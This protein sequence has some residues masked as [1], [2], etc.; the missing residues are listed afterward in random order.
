M[1][2]C[3]R[4]YVQIARIEL[5]CDTTKFA[6]DSG[7]YVEIWNFTIRFWILIPNSKRIPHA[8]PRIDVPRCRRSASRAR[9][10]FL[11]SHTSRYGSRPFGWWRRSERGRSQLAE[12]DLRARCKAEAHLFHRAVR[13]LQPPRC[14]HIG[15]LI[16]PVGCLI[17]PCCIGPG[18]HANFTTPG[19]CMF[20][21]RS[22]GT[23]CRSRPRRYR[24]LRSPSK[25]RARNSA[26]RLLLCGNVS[27]ER[28]VERRVYPNSQS[29]DLASRIEDSSGRDKRGLSWTLEKIIYVTASRGSQKKS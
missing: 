9:A 22:C 29:P 5:S 2:S 24:D 12:A 8:S 19:K 27:R 18:P 28:R 26:T 3:I 14:T 16:L 17:A 25:S 13:R 21:R 23:T 11:R 10:R 7:H 15:S 4:L 20:R 6:N 1:Q